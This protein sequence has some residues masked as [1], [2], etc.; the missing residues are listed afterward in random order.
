MAIKAFL[1]RQN[2]SPSLGPVKCLLLFLSHIL[3]LN[4]FADCCSLDGH[5]GCIWQHINCE[6]LCNNFCSQHNDQFYSGLHEFNCFTSSE[7]WGK[8]VQ[9]RDHLHKYELTIQ[10]HLHDFTAN[11]TGSWRTSH[12]VQLNFANQFNN[13]N[14]HFYI[15]N[16]YICVYI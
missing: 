15:S 13:C 4:V 1:G 9:W 14:Y 8:L 10:L 2:C 7:V 5:S 12:K 3:N 11:N 6:R 16:F